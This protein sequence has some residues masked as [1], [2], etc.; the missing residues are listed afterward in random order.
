[1]DLHLIK[2]TNKSHRNFQIYLD[3]EA[4]IKVKSVANKYGVSKRRVSQIFRK[5]QRYHNPDIYY[6]D[7]EILFG[8]NDYKEKSPLTFRCF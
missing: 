3:V 2:C 5:F 4:G 8:L 7:E 6:M 1:M